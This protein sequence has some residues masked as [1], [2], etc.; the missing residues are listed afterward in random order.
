[1][2][3]TLLLLAAA[4]GCAARLTAQ[5]SGAAGAGARLPG[6]TVLDGAEPRAAGVRTLADVDR[7]EIA[8]GPMA[9]LEGAGAGTGVINV[10]SGSAAARGRNPVPPGAAIGRPGDG[11]RGGSRRRT[12]HVGKRMRSSLPA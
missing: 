8:I 12:A 5:D 9:R 7:I 10:I 6:V 1:V 3:A 2:N 4:L 11:Q